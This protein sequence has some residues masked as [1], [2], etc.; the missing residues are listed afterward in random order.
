MRLTMRPVKGWKRSL[1][2]TARRQIRGRGRLELRRTWVLSDVD[3]LTRSD[4]WSKLS[5][6]VL[7]EAHRTIRGK[8]SV[9]RRV[10]LSSL[11]DSAQRHAT[12]IRDHWQVENKPHWVLDVT[13]GE[14]HGRAAKRCGTENLAMFRKL[15]VTLL[16]RSEPPARATSIV[17]RR[18]KADRRLWYL[19]DVLCAGLP[20]AE[21]YG[22][23]G[24]FVRSSGAQSPP[25]ACEAKR[26]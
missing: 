17:S 6:L 25:E 26:S 12:V 18:R 22:A 21:A 14:D 5:P 16:S 4:V 7:V 10:H 8:T 3:W 20:A 24:G 9:Q 13:F 23:A 15:A 11:V 2:H 1:Q 19:R